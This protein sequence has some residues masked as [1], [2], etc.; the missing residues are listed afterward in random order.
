MEKLPIE[1][2]LNQEATPKFIE[3]NKPD[4]VIVAAGAY[5]VVPDIP[6]IEGNNVAT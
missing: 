3:Q 6:G 1:V 5:P 4:V 2:K